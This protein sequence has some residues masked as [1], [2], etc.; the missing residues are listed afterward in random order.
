VRR[1]G[2]AALLAVAGC[3][4]PQAL[5][6]RTVADELR[7]E[8]GAAAA[9]P[10]AAV[11]EEQA[12]ALA[13]RWNPDLRVA[14]RQRAIAQGEVVAATAL[15]NPTLELEL[16]HLE[17]YGGRKAWG[18]QLGWEPPQPVVLSAKRAA[19]WAQVDA[20]GS[21]IAEA[22]WQL[23]VAVRAAHARLLAI[24]E[25]RG[26][27]EQAL[28]TRHKVAELVER[29]LGGGAS[30]RLDLSLAQ[31][32]VGQ[33]ERDRD[34]LSD[35]ELAARRELGELVGAG[36][37]LGA[38][39]SIPEEP[40][41]PAAPD[42]L[43]DAAL[44]ARPALRAQ[45][46]R[47]AQREQEVRLEDARAWPWFRFTAA[48]RY[49]ADVSN[50]HPDDFMVALQF[51]LP[52][53]DQNQGPIAVARGLRDQ[54]RERFRG[55]V[56]G[57]RREI[58]AASDEVGLHQ[59]TLRRYRETVLP[60]LDAHSRLLSIAVGGGQLDLVAVLNAEGAILRSRRD[61]VDS[62]LALYRAW[63]RLE[64]TVGQRVTPP[65]PPPDPPLPGPPGRGPG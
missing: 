61:H 21:E 8:E 22:E 58:A 51:T 27:V 5:D 39:G 44:T 37:P 60:G 32:A 42:R 4:H 13:L 1:A 65:T 62:R 52:I 18:L 48:P 53:F 2:P 45:E 19:A 3:Y 49:R 56:A 55:Q 41:P 23:A 38:I 25:Q 11:T 54:Q 20:V 40:R 50:R 63:L 28:Q 26:L 64:A 35:Q 24:G 14:R 30:T 59:R 43:V 6:A 47:Y 36:H 7:A 15:S 46:K 16:L 9:A 57:L 34:E 31:L 33:G 17:D 12:V 29:R 10:A